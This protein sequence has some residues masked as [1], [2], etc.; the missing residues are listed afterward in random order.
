MGSLKEFIRCD[1]IDIMLSL[2]SRFSSHPLISTFIDN[3]AFKYFTIEVDE[4]E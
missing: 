1:G 3:F 2:T 4:D